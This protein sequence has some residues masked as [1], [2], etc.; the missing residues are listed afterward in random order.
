M[1][2]ETLCLVSFI[3]VC[4]LYF[5][6]HSFFHLPK[7]TAHFVKIQFHQSLLFQ[8][9]TKTLELSHSYR[10]GTSNSCHQKESTTVP[11]GSL[12]AYAVLSLT[13]LVRFIL[14][15]LVLSVCVHLHH[16]LLYSLF[17]NSPSVH[18]PPP[19]HHFTSLL[20]SVL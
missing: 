15:V 14:S 3:F 9:V 12:H 10:F 20:F 5:Q 11:V 4:Y 16:S 1:P 2:Q 19:H 7:T 18:C 13:T 17:S 8:Q 6:L